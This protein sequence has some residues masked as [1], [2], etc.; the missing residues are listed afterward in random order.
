MELGSG[1]GFL[2]RSV[3]DKLP[4][5]CMYIAV[6]HNKKRHRFLKSMLER[7]DV[8][9]NIVFICADFLHMPIEKESVDVVFDFAGTSNFSFEKSTFLLDEVNHYLKKESYL[10]AN[11]IVFKNFS[12]NSIIKDIF[13]K[14][15]VIQNIKEHITNLGYDAIDERTS[16]YIDSGGKYENYFVEGEKIFSYLFFGKR[17]G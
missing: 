15:F 14:N 9:K 3:F 1:V 10:V 13:K 8:K 2:L 4:D 6:D 7:A 11:Y 16:D 12:A 5:D 17:S